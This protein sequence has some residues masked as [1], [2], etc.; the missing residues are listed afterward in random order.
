M[1]HKHPVQAVVLGHAMI[2]ALDIVLVHVTV[3]AMEVA[4]AVVQVVQVLAADHAVT[5]VLEVL[6]FVIIKL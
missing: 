6:R 5:H 1:P 4:T 2:L 3:I